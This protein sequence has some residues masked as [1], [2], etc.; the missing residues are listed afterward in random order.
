MPR[1]FGT[2]HPL[3]NGRRMAPPLRKCGASTNA[4]TLEVLPGNAL[5]L[6]SVDTSMTPTLTAC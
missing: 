6:Q 4:M 3:P 5:N 2:R 1:P